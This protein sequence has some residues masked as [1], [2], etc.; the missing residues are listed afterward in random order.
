MIDDRANLFPIPVRRDPVH[1]WVWRSTGEPLTVDECQHRGLDGT[2]RDHAARRPTVLPTWDVT[3]QDACG[4]IVLVS[5]PIDDT[6][7]WLGNRPHVGWITS[8]YHDGEVVV[9]LPDGRVVITEPSQLTPVSDVAPFAAREANGE[10]PADV[11]GS[12]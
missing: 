2:G 9:V 3:P 4:R 11:I 12:Y 1:G 5:A 6:R 8:G 7:R 10:H